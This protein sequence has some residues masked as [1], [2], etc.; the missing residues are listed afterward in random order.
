MKQEL[1][2]FEYIQMF[3]ELLILHISAAVHR[4][5]LYFLC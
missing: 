4:Q 3:P 1:H 2:G 5:Y